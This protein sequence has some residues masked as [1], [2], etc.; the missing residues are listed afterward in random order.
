MLIQRGV[1]EDLEK[2]WLMSIAPRCALSYSE[3]C[4]SII[5]VFFLMGESTIVM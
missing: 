4:F 1:D 5:D 2:P 3:N